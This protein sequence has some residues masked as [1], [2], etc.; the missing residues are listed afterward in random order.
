[1]CDVSSDAVS[2]G[3]YH[4]MWCGAERVTRAERFEAFSVGLVVG[5]SIVIPHLRRAVDR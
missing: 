2:R 5:E 4:M 1:M 3:A